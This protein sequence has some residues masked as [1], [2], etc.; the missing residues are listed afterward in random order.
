TRTSNLIDLKWYFC[1]YK[2]NL[3]ETKK[4]YKLM[5]PFLAIISLKQ[6]YKFLLG[7]KNIYV[8]ELKDHFIA[9]DYKLTGKL[10]AFDESKKE[11]QNIRKESQESDIILLFVLIFYLLF[12]LFN[13]FL[14]LKKNITTFA[15]KYIR[16]VLTQK[17][18][19]NGND[20]DNYVST[21]HLHP[22]LFHSFIS[23]SPAAER[24]KKHT[25]KKLW[26]DMELLRI[27]NEIQQSHK[28]AEGNKKRVK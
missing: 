20:K 9:V 27:F 4:R 25:V 28:V 22:H 16:L 10:E 2:K 1:K 14:I 8:T 18:E 15:E 17:H 7:N 21:T 11:L 19:I 26:I 5:L 13:F 23:P 3:M 24:K 6:E 12:Y